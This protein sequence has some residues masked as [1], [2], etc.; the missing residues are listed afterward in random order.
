MVKAGL[1]C[2]RLLTQLNTSDQKA[3]GK[4]I[5][6]FGIGLSVFGPLPSISPFRAKS[7]TNCTMN[8]FRYRQYSGM[9]NT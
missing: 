4:A 9:P 1:W 5:N 6:L 2:S 7:P 3:V 8:D